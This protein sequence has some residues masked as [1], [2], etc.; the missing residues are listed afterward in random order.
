METLS[1]GLALLLFAVNF[2]W[3]PASS[4]DD[5]PTD[6]GY[7]Y[8]VK[9]DAEELRALGE[10]RVRELTS[11]PPTDL[12]RIDRVTLVVGDEPPPRRLTA[13]DRSSPRRI[14]ASDGPV[15]Q[16][17]AKPVA[18]DWLPPRGESGS[19]NDA[20][21]EPQTR[22]SYQNPQNFNPAAVEQGFQQGS[23]A[24]TDAAQ[25]LG[26]ATQQTGQ[27]LR[28]GTV[29]FLGGLRDAVTSGV[30]GTANAINNTVNIGNDQYYNQRQP[31]PAPPANTGQAPRQFV[32]FSYNQ[33]NANDIAAPTSASP[34]FDRLNTVD[35]ANQAATPSQFTTPATQGPTAAD[36]RFGPALPPDNRPTGGDIATRFGGGGGGGG[37]QQPTAMNNQGFDRGENTRLA[38]VNRFANDSRTAPADRDFGNTPITAQQ[39][40]SAAN[41]DFDNWRGSPQS[42]PW[43]GDLDRRPVGGDGFSTPQGFGA[44]TQQQQFAQRPAG[45]PGF[46]Q[47]PGFANQGALQQQ[48]PSQQV[49]SQQGLQQNG[50]NTD[51][52]VP[53]VTPTAATTPISQATQ[54]PAEPTPPNPLQDALLLVLLAGSI[55]GNLYV[56]TGYLDVRNKYRAALRQ[57]PA[58]PQRMAA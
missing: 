27:D 7:E 54:Q 39:R 35:P 56:V 42:D 20:P 11:A 45:N 46:G 16:M 40:P 37:A 15:R 1:G 33:P 22:T 34:S 36:Q 9:V 25:D 8:I 12:R 28:D 21:P 29:G 32:P 10:G 38:P 48:V 6:A 58:G 47:S 44:P 51:G 31:Q 17:V 43:N 24:F 2:G 53:G 50:Q 52:W 23:N 14:A 19:S 3:V 41:T 13:V 57:M 49:P 26:R 30:E 4:G 5:T 55:A 18:P